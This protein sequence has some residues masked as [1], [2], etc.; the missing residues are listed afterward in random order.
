MTVKADTLDLTQLYDAFAGE[1]SSAA[2]PAGTTTS[3]GSA[4]AGNVEPEPVK[5]PMQLTVEAN[6]GQV[7]LHEIAITNWQTTAK[8]DGGRITLDPCRLTLN[9]A[10]VTA[11]LDLNLG[12]KGYTYGISLLMDK[13]PLEP[14]ANTFSPASRGQYQGLIL[15]S[16]QIKGAGVTGASLQKNL[17]GQASFTFTNANLQ[18]IGPKTKNLIVPIATLLRV[19]EIAQTPLNWLD[20]QT[21][22]GGGNIKLNKFTVQSAAFEVRN[23]R[24]YS[25]GRNAHQFAA[26]SAGR[27]RPAPFAGGEVQSA[28]AERPTNATYATLP[29]FVTVKGTIGEPKSDLNELALGG[30]LLK[31]G[32]GIAEKLGVKADS[33]A[34]NMLQGVGGL[35]TGQK[36]ATT[37]QPGTNAAPKLNP[38]DLFRTPTK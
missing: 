5:L 9:G 34:G 31:S 1:K 3:P 36:P 12:I 32:E 13:V 16:L 11:S 10:R 8:V 21:E 17:G 26:Q 6:L 29:Q 28:A 38:L 33:T 35:L 19:N 22:L 7:Y 4:S 20:A 25:H 30:L 15:A 27:I 14:I 24:R 2:T 37:N 23:A 18:V